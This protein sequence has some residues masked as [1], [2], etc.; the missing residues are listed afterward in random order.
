MRN[1]AEIQL[2]GYVYQDA[3]C[4]NEQTYPNWV[5]FKLCVNKKYK[6]KSGEE[7]RDTTWFECKSNSEGMSKNI[8]DYV[9]DKMGLLVKGIPKARA[10]TSNSGTAEA[11]IE[12]LVTDFNILTYPRE[13]ETDKITYSTAPLNKGAYP[14]G[15]FETGKYKIES[16]AKKTVPEVELRDDE[17]PF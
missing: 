12:V 10:Y 11:S 15:Q 1:S 8:K 3:K 14:Q 6:D 7:Q 13:V 16:G 5:T 9:K 17:I 4:P 2:I